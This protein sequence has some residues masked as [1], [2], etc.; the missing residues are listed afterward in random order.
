VPGPRRT[1]SCAIG[2]GR[3]GAAAAGTHRAADAEPADPAAGGDGRHAAAAAQAGG[4]PAD[5]GGQRAGGIPGRAVAHRSRDK[6]TRQAAGRGGRSCGSS[7]R[8]PCRR[9]SPSTSRR[10]CGVRP[11]PQG[12]RWPGSRRRR[13]GSS[14]RSANTGPTPAIGGALSVGRVHRYGP[15]PSRRISPDRRGI[16]PSP[17][18]LALA[19]REPGRLR[20]PSLAEHRR[21]KEETSQDQERLSALSARGV[22]DV[23]S[24][25]H[26]PTPDRRAGPGRSR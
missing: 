20:N 19:G 4:R 10:G 9:T 21:R 23:S 24:P 1:S 8:R 15:R 18:T 3:T 13:T 6:P 22:T 16:S 12:S 25:A 5:R 2:R 14:R 17:R 11:R 7:C 26:T